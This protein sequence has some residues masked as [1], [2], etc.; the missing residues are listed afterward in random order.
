MTWRWQIDYDEGVNLH[1]AWLLAHGANIYLPN[2]P[3]RFISAPYPP[4][5]Y[6]LTVPRSVLGGIQLLGPRLLVLR[7]TLAIAAC[8]LPR[9]PGARG[10]AGRLLAAAIWLS[11]RPVIIW[12]G[13]Y[14]Q[15]MVA[16]ALGVGGLCGDRRGR[17]PHAARPGRCAG[18]LA[19]FALAFF[20]KQSALAPAAAAGLADPARP[21]RGLALRRPVAGGWGPGSSCCSGCRAAASGST[22]SSI[23]RCPGPS[24]SGGVWRAA[25]R[26]V[27]AA[28][29]HRPGG[30][31][32]RAGRWNPRLRHRARAPG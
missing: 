22:P 8:Y 24:T 13:V 31:R 18:R 15:D 17:A 3:D 9:A 6:L 10:L 16:L 27:L 21:A 2:P 5:L 28:A 19:L 26:R 4:L 11:S 20:T 29:A 14:K 32:P 30:V 1:A 7:G 12:A 25:H 23:R